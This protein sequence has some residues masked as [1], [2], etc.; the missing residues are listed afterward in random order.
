MVVYRHAASFK[1]Q[2]D[3]TNSLHLF[4]NFLEFPIDELKKKRDDPK[5]IS[6]IKALFMR[7]SQM[8]SH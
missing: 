2:V 6:G 1:Y 5:I 3:Y 7:I 4:S 8:L